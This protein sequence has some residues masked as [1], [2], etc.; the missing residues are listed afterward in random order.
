MER[1]IFPPIELFPR[2]SRAAKF[3]RDARIRHNES[4]LDSP[5]E[6]VT[7]LPGQPEYEAP[8]SYYFKADTEPDPDEAA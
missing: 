7:S 8:G 1:D 2:V 4:P 3:I 5:I 6:A